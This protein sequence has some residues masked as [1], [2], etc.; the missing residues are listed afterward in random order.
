MEL[1]NGIPLIQPP[2]MN[3]DTPEGNVPLLCFI[4]QINH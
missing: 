1:H 4:V 2:D 3:E